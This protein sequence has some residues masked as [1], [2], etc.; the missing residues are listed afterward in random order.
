MLTLHDN[1][2]EDEDVSEDEDVLEDDD[3]PVVVTVESAELVG[4][5][6]G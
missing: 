3:V 6:D 1:L 4:C 5:E 2:E